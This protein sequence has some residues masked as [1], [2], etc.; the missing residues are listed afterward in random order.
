MVHYGVYENQ[1]LVSSIGLYKTKLIS[2]YGHLEAYCIGAVSTHPDYRLRGYFKLLM[3][4][5]ID[6]AKKKKADLL[7]LGGNRL[8]YGYFGFEN[9]GRTLSFDIS[10]RTKNLLHV[11][12]YEVSRLYKIDIANI[13]SCLKLYNLKSQRVVRTTKDFYDYLISWKCIPYVV[14]ENGIVIGY[15]SI[16]DKAIY[17]FAYK[18]RFRDFV[19]DDMLKDNDFVN[20]ITSTNELNKDL[21]NKIDGYSV[22]HN[23]MYLV[24]KWGNVARYLN[25]KDDSLEKLKKQSKKEMIINGLG[26]CLN[27]SSYGYESMFISMLDK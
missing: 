3:K 10:S 6:Y 23:D 16:N 18:K 20:V 27:E 7:F 26:S 9:A 25:F 12:E 11:K 4:K 14:K 2:K 13:K 1:K 22:L 15:Y 19:L 5:V 21:L 17:E 24:L 8:R